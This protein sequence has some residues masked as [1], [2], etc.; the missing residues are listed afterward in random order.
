MTKPT[1]PIPKADA[2]N[3]VL[4]KRKE[5]SAAEIL[6]KSK[7]IFERLIEF[8]ILNMQKNSGICF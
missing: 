1:L 7:R 3:L 5:L 8:M 4:E 2:R 6:D